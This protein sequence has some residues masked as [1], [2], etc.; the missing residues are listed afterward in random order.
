MT[1]TKLVA[2]SS[3]DLTAL[4]GA[5]FAAAPLKICTAVREYVDDSTLDLA[6]MADDLHSYRGHSSTS[7]PNEADW[8]A[9]FGDAEYIFCVTISSELSGSYNA[10]CAAK[11]TYEAQH[12]G[13]RVAVVDSRSTGPEM[14]LLLEHLRD[15]IAAGDDFD[16]AYASVCAYQRRTRILFMLESME[17]LANNGRVSPLAAKA[18]GLLG[19]RVV[20]RGSEE[21]RLVPLD[22]CRGEEKAL[23]AIVRRMKELG[24]GAGKVYITHCFNEPAAQRLREK[25]LAVSAAAQI[26][27]YRCGGLCSYY[28]ERGGLIIGFEAD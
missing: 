11:K 14:A 27:I 25:I 26:R 12:P 28:A 7:C 23:S 2:D 10:A 13:R 21:G 22:K 3:C 8:L 6:G 15:R 19:I 4:P 20:G 5:S 17:N 24:H 1:N 16:A 18:A 9:A